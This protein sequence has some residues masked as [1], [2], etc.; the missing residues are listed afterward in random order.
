MSA[1]PQ[2]TS[3]AAGALPSA[4]PPQARCPSQ[5]WIDLEEAA[6]RSGWNI[7][8][9]RRLCAD[10]ARCP[11]GTLLSRGLARLRAPDGGGKPRWE[12]REDANEKFARVKFAEQMS[13]EQ[14][15]QR[16]SLSPAQRDQIDFRKRIIDGWEEQLRAGQV[17]KVSREKITASYI[18]RLL[19]SGHADISRGTLYNWH[20]SYRQG[21]EMALLDGRSKAAADVA[22]E[23]ATDPF[24]QYA[25]ALY[26]TPRKRSMQLSWEM[27]QE[28]AQAEGW[29][30][31]TYKDFQ[32]HV[33]TLPPQ[34]LVKMRDGDDAFV[35]K[36]E[37]AIE[38]DYSTL[39]SNDIWCADD[40]RFDVS[41]RITDET[42]KEKF[43]RPFLTGFEDMRSR[44]IVGWKI[45]IESP[46]AETVLDAFD[47]A[48]DA[49]GVPLKVYVDNGKHYDGYATQ[50]RTKKRR[51]AGEQPDPFG[52]A[53]SILGVE[54]E[55]AW[56]YHGQS[57]PIERA[58]RTVCERFSKLW[59]TYCGNAPHTRPEDHQRHLDAGKA[60]TLA[61]FTAA[62]A[63]WLES[64]YHGRLHLGDAMDGK[65]PARVFEENLD[66]K[67]TLPGELRAFAC[68]IP[69]C[70]QKKRRD[71]SI[72]RGVLVGK[73][74]VTWD[75]MS[76]GAF[77]PEVQKLFGTRVSLRVRR[78]DISRV[79]V[80]SLDGKLLA[81]APANIRLGCNAE[82]QDKRDAIATKKQ[83]RKTLEKYRQ[84]RPQMSQDLPELVI[85][86]GRRRRAAARASGAEEPLDPPPLKPHRTAFDSQLQ[87][88][89]R[90]VGSKAVGAEN[91]DLDTLRPRMPGP[92]AGSYDGG[93]GDADGESDIDVFAAVSAAMEKQRRG[94][95]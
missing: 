89:Q 47:A 87:Q 45:V 79:F 25:Q 52:G 40:H 42:G 20:R 14:R 72:E 64:D 60:P 93:G 94:E 59:D 19:L 39:R 28:K 23:K 3:P 21:G 95:P 18:D 6:R 61:E 31:R 57:K 1:A 9:I 7:G 37:P 32:R 48:V 84:Q 26:L 35:A 15:W 91:L 36:C 66:V 29:R 81:V 54:V 74:G 67:R 13:E 82:A 88:I 77:S 92:A 11:D 4:G 5:M 2:T 80:V 83:L 44:K 90:A 62:F 68:S 8:Y 65:T 58:F 17:L 12:V 46:N 85:A 30:H 53:F 34:L 75:G 73:Q 16:A 24:L 71:G 33:A 69:F 78:H 49:N 55:H 51:R 50:G 86:A 38:R 41:I 56:I 22:A 27:A 76:F 10:A 43:V 70:P 63:E